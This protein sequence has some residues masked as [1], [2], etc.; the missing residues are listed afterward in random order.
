[1]KF[2]LATIL[3]A[4][5]LG[6]TSFVFCQDVATDADKTAKDAGHDT[7]V[8][9]QKTG[10]ATEKAADKTGDATKTAATKTGHAAKT[11]AADTVKEPIRLAAKPHMPPRP[12]VTTLR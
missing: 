7:K 5:L 10:H 4:L 11:G 2:K 9:A 12:S 1:M 6:A 3:A 8:A